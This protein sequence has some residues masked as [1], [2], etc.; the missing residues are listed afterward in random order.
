M[1][2]VRDDMV[3]RGLAFMRNPKVADTDMAKKVAFL[4]NKGLTADELAEV[5]RK[6]E[7]DPEEPAVVAAR[8]P[9]G[10]PPTVDSIRAAITALR[11]KLQPDAEREALLATINVLEHALAD[12]TA[13]KSTPVTPASP[14]AP[15]P[16]TP[17]AAASPAK[18]WEG[19]KK[20]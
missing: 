8:R 13:P 6:Y 12:E 18:P 3:A 2:E 10:P 17:A 1:P 15:A 7:A 20:T 9:S 16:A 19:P 11:A 4:E 5:V 14:A